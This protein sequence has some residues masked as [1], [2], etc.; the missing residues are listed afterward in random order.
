MECVAK[1]GKNIAPVYHLGINKSLVATE[2][3]VISTVLG[4][5][6]S[7]CLYDV[8]ALVGGMN[9]YMLPFCFVGKEHD[10]LRF[11]ETS[12]PLLIKKMRQAGACKIRAKIFGGANMYP[13]AH[14][15]TL[16]GDNIKVARAILAHHGI[17]I[18]KEDVGGFTGRAIRFCSSNGQVQ[19]KKHKK[20][21]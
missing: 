8:K 19:V 20:Q 17:K 16:A 2:P 3:T 13:I 10:V 21:N 11:G 5:C 4:S 1:C 9:H 18:E 14:N 15:N 12:I 6:V 7:V